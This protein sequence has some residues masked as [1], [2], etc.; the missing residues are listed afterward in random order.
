MASLA[1]LGPGSSV[2]WLNLNHQVKYKVLIICQVSVMG[3][4]K[5]SMTWIL[6]SR[7][8]LSRRGEKTYSQTTKTECDYTIKGGKSKFFASPGLWLKMGSWPISH[9][10][11]PLSEV[12]EG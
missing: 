1:A 6:L 4:R 5:I 2:T 8:L 3:D 7:N 9:A 12:R 10:S 11:G